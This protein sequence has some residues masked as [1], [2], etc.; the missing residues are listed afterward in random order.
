LP[1]MREGLTVADVAR[2]A[3]V[4]RET[5]HE[6]VCRFSRC[7]DVRD[8]FCNPAGEC[9]DISG[10]KVLAPEGLF[11]SQRLL[12]RLR[13][14]G[15]YSAGPAA[16][17]S[18]STRSALRPVGGRTDRRCAPR[19]PEARLGRRLDVAACGTTLPAPQSATGRAFFRHL[20]VGHGTRRHDAL[21][22]E[23]RACDPYR[24]T[25]TR[26]LTTR[27]LTDFGRRRSTPFRRALNT[28][29]QPSH[30]GTP[31]ATSLSAPDR[32]VR[33]I[34]YARRHPPEGASFTTPY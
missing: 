26:R 19:A 7:R 33:A 18:P 3:R 10:R 31:G 20:A 16:A 9:R 22:V 8:R 5:H 30:D 15:E 17:V 6:Q 14:A 23:R 4:K 28:R 13:H 2:A 12:G 29:V 27:R 32:Q 25:L 34:D 11:L 1:L 21:G 24:V